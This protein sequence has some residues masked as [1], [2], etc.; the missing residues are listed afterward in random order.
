M[1]EATTDSV[2]DAIEAS[3]EAVAEADASVAAADTSTP[4]ADTTGVVTDTTGVSEDTTGVKTD[5]TDAPAGETPEEKA[6]RE[7]LRDQQGKFAEPDKAVKK[8]GITPAPKAG[9]PP[10]KADP[11][12]R[13]PQAWKPE[14]RE[15][16][17]DIPEAAR[18]E[19]IRTEQSI[20][21]TLRDTVED[22]RF[23][24]AIKDTIRPFEHF[25][26][27]EGSDPVRAIDNLLT[28]AAR[29]RT[30]NVT[31]V[32]GMMTELVK[33]FGV[34]RF[35]NDFIRALDSSLSGAA[36]QQQ[37]DPYVSQMEQRLN[38]IEQRDRMNAQYAEQQRSAVAEQEIMSFAETAEFI[39]DVKH[40]M[41]DIIELANSRGQAIGLKEAYDR[42]CWANPEIRSILTQRQE[43]E[44]AQQTNQVAQKARAA[45]VSVGGS[46][47]FN[48]SQEAPSSIRDA[49]EF[50]MRK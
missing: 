9:Q 2:R 39:G 24:G 40:D 38:Q 31:E 33:Q 34:G 36:P 30:G 50:A 15:F 16:W 11:I 43:R 7:Y 18:R 46:P 19:I 26:K 28:T 12:E 1:T 42:A 32:A 27:A 41:A 35:G 20:Q 4:P 13:A 37:R 47:A 5:T 49:I 23:A 29:L 22:R 8:D 45:A 48:A 10:A 14:A 6:K 17:K 3:Y 25:I 44:R 21:Q